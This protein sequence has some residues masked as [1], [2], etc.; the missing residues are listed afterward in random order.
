MCAGHHLELAAD[1]LGCERPIGIL[2]VG[3]RRLQFLAREEVLLLAEAAVERVN[4]GAEVF[5]F[6]HGALSSSVPSRW[7]AHWRARL[8]APMERR[9]PSIERA[10]SLAGPVLSENSGEGLLGFVSH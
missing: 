6:G 10:A 5:G 4:G 7:D 9:A 8:Q 1:E 2:E 3:Y